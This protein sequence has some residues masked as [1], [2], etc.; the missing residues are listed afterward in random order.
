MPKLFFRTRRL[1]KADNFLLSVWFIIIS[2]LILLCWL[3][4]FFL[5]P[6]AIYKTS[7][8]AHIEMGSS[9]VTIAASIDGTVKTINLEAQQKVV[10]DTVLVTLDDEETHLALK[11]ITA[12]YQEAKTDAS[13]AKEEFTRWKKL[14]DQKLLPEIDLLRQKAK[15]EKLND[16]ANA[17]K[18]KKE[19]LEFTLKKHQIVAP[20]SGIAGCSRTFGQSIQ[21]FLQA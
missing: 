14:Y 1:I 11:E 19:L 12:L 4:W 2:L 7:P 5:Y 21:N 15:M 9:P 20:I 13:F 6:V 17:L 10:K 18:A 8:Q 16:A 3:L